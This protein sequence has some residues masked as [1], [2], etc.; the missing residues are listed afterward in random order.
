MRRSAI[1]F[2]LLVMVAGC[3]KV[4]QE[5]TVKMEPGDSIAAFIIDPP[6]SEQ[7]VNLIVSSDG[8]PVDVYIATVADADAFQKE[9][10]QDSKIP[11]GVVTTKS[12]VEKEETLTATIP[13]KKP[14]VVIL[15]NP[16]KATNV[17]LKLTGK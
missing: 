7:T 4:S 13:A 14:Y 10:A 16:T 12:K 9:F 1:L 2:A 5:K 3:Q 17:K 6:S 15:A 11:A 8:G